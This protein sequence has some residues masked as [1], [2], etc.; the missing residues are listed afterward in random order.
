VVQQLLQ[1]R[2]AA[3]MLLKVHMEPM[4]QVLPIQPPLILGLP[5]RARI[6]F[7]TD[8]YFASVPFKEY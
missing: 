2:L 3:L 4:M 5:T 7:S 6:N 1:Q 8:V